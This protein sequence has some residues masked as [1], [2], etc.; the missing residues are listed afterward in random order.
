MLATKLRKPRLNY[1][2]RLEIALGTHS[3][4]VLLEFI[5][6]SVGLQ[7]LRRVIL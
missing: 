2:D 6:C 1:I 5:A 3:S 4:M 7:N